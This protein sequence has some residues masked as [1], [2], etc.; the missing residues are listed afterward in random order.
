[1]ISRRK[2]LQGLAVSPLLTLPCW[3]AAQNAKVRRLLLI[4]LNGGNDGLNTVIPFSDPEYRRLRPTLGLDRD[5]VLQLDARTGLHPALEPLMPMFAAREMAII[6]SVGYPQQSRSHFRSIDIWDTASDAGTVSTEGWLTRVGDATR[7]GRDLK[8]DAVV[9]GRNPAAVSGG[10]LE[11]IV[12]SSIERFAIEAR[13]V[14]LS[15]ARNDNPALHHLL[16]VQREVSKAVVSLGKDRPPVRVE[17]PPQPFG[18]EMAE[19][20]RILTG[21]PLTAIVKV[22]ITGFDTHA[23]QAGPHTHQLRV[24]AQSLAAFRTAMKESGDWNDTLVLTYSEF[25]RRAAENGSQGTDHGGAAPHFAFG[26]AVRGGLYGEAPALNDLSN[27]DVRATTDFRSM[28]NTVLGRWWGLTQNEIE[29][30]RYP[31]LGFV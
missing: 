5:A 12:M 1:M 20:A 24:L 6:Q 21:I 18:R 9:I 27:G 7:I 2:I 22:A 11:P 13:D 14:H 28:Y 26:G 8:L 30:T 3:A 29:P 10:T 4:E 25:G 19:A 15:S 31:K 23:R 16:Q 17:F